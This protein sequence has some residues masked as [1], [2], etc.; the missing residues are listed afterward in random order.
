[1]VNWNFNANDY[2]EKSFRPI[3]AGD[4]RVR[5][6]DAIEK[7][8]KSGNDMIEVTLEVSGH[9][10][11]VWY[12]IVLKADDVKKTNQRLGEFWNSFGIPMGNFALNTW[13]GK[14]GGAKIV[15]EEYEGN[16][17]AKVAYL[18]GRDRQEKL[19]AWREPTVNSSA[20]FVEVKVDEAELPFF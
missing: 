18:L 14:V 19:E 12:Y 2:E 11:K 1:M 9:N 16:T 6:F 17:N 3:P 10:A 13:K 7:K 5:I 20:A 8:S 4:H 15:H